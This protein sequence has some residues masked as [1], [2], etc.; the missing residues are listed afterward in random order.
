MTTLVFLLEEP[1][2]KA[3]LQGLVP[4]LLGENVDARYLVFEGKQDLEAQLTR[5]L[6]G[7]GVP[8]SRFVVMRD[9]DASGC[10]DVKDKLSGLV[11]QSGKGALVR[12]ACREL[13]AWV[14]GDLAAVARAFGEPAVAS[15]SNKEKYRDP[16]ALHNP[17]EE[18]RR[19]VPHYQKI[20]GA[21]RLGRLLDP[22][23]NASTS[24]R[25]FCEGLVRHTASR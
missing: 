5:K 7:W 10:H 6:R 14:V 2:A 13:E 1:S 3:L 21:R 25:A 19:L 8:N 9:Q 18:L 24:F 16:D 23:T 15:I 22:H 4:R 11:A 12:I 20:D 17:V